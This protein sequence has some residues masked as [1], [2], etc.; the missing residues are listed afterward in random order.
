MWRRV[1]CRSN[2][3]HADVRRIEAFW[4]RIL[5]VLLI[6]L[7]LALLVSPRVAYSERERIAR[8]RYTVKREK[9]ILVPG[10]V[11]VLIAGS[12]ALVLVLVRTSRN[13]R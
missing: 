12:G 9:A 3:Y 11:A 5:G 4:L 1:P 2:C 6:L 10:P 8:T 7:G 13:R